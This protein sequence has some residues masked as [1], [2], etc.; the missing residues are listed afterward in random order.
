MQGRGV[1]WRG[2]ARIWWCPA[3]IPC[4]SFVAVRPTALVALWNG[5]DHCGRMFSWGQGSGAMRIPFI[6][7][8]SPQQN[9][10]AAPE[11]VQHQD[12]DHL[13]T[14]GGPV[15]TTTARALEERRG[16]LTSARPRPGSHPPVLNKGLWSSEQQLSSIQAPQNRT[17]HRIEPR[18]DI[19]RGSRGNRLYC[20]LS[21]KYLT[22]AGGRGLQGGLQAVIATPPLPARA[23]P[24]GGLTPVV[25]ASGESRAERR[26]TAAQYPS[27]SPP[28]S[29]SSIGLVSAGS[30]GWLSGRGGGVHKG[31]Q[32]TGVFGEKGGFLPALPFRRTLIEPS[33]L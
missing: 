2:P 28:P 22:K 6:V 20:A 24:P 7:G 27:R 10:E 33:Q 1:A 13:R 14:W 11:R 29:R 21:R 9:G 8:I 17:A 23:Q 26:C 15:R 19:A 18:V 4:H 16:E 3:R 5:T 31:F 32:K 30:R 25:R 12:H